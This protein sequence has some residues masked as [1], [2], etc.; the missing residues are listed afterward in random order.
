MGVQE[1]GIK[2]HNTGIPFHIYCNIMY[3]MNNTTNEHSMI[4]FKCGAFYDTNFSF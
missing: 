1:E 3:T 4:C 2:Q